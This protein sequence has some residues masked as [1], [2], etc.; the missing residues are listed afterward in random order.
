[1]RLDR[2][3][4][5]AAALSLL[6]GGVTPV[7][8]E[9]PAGKTTWADH[10]APIMEQ[11]CTYC[12]DA[13]SPSGGLDLTSYAGAMQGGGSGA[14]IVPG[15][16]D[17]S[18]LF[19][20]VSKAAQ[21]YMPDDGSELPAEA[22]ATLRRWIE[23]GALETSSSPAPRARKKPA[24]T[25]ESGPGAVR[26]G[27]A[28]PAALALAGRGGER[29]PPA[30]LALA[31]SPSA[32]L[33][34]VGGHREVLLYDT[35]GD[36]LVGVL[37]FPQGRVHV[38]RFSP[39]GQTLLAAGG[40]G[41]AGGRASLFEV[42]SGALRL[43]VDD[44]RD[45]F[46][47][48][49]VREDLAQLAVGGPTR[50]VAVHGLR[51]GAPSYEL[52]AHTDWITA[53]AFSPDGTLL[54]SADRA[55][56]LH[57]WEADSGQEFLDLEAHG[58]PITALAW[59]RD[60]ELLASA[61]DSGH[62]RLFQ[63][64]D[65][66]KH[67]E[68]LAHAGGALAVTWTPDGRLLSSG[69]DGKVVL[70]TADG[71]PQRVLGPLGAEG[72]AATWLEGALE[73]AA[74]PSTPAPTASPAGGGPSGARA[75]AGDLAGCVHGFALGADASV[76]ASASWPARA[77]SLTR[78]RDEARTALARAQ[79]GREDQERRAAETAAVAST[80]LEAGQ[81]AG[82]DA[83]EARALVS[84][85]PELLVSARQL[86]AGLES[87]LAA[88]R[89]H[90]QARA[91]A[92]AGDPGRGDPAPGDPAQDAVAAAERD[93]ARTAELQQALDEARAELA[94]VASQVAARRQVLDAAAARAEER[95]A[96]LEAGAREAAA[97]NLAATSA[98]TRAR[99]VER[100]AAREAQ[101]W[102]VEVELAQV[103]AALAAA[104]TRVSQARA[105]ADGA[106]A[107]RDTTARAQAQAVQAER[108]AREALAAAERAAAR[109]AETVPP[110]ETLRTALAESLRA[111]GEVAH[112]RSQALALA[113]PGEQAAAHVALLE[114][115]SR[116]ERLANEHA[117]A[118]AALEVARKE[119]AARQAA[120][121]QTRAGVDEAARSSARAAQAAE[122]A[123]AAAER[124]EAALLEATAGHSAL[125][126]QLEELTPRVAALRQG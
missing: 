37:P 28:M 15:D 26:R 90:A 96:A 32:P 59:R 7:R 121:S 40:E 108:S 100:G 17:G 94:S 123:R 52:T 104:R 97:A 115:E 95:A 44:A 63:A 25:L 66:K 116:R 39:D 35:R 118:G 109:V 42:A 47:A 106:L 24:L 14:V 88:A 34:A 27:G 31:A 18:R 3:L 75:Y 85:D 72:L 45:A 29:R 112:V 58:A 99:E 33:L 71:K 98:L 105:A 70:W 19:R 78:L 117:L 125:S 122:E 22:L 79:A 114:A 84:Q 38:L 120:L 68:W 93:R 107:A 103:Q 126:R 92:A 124:A 56:G 20:L 73:A 83:A 54:A 65:G 82:R 36:G 48:A 61:A 21:P 80:S 16:P 6:G 50:V 91:Q 111:A 13:G 69:R 49:D 1:M 30:V 64:Q 23:Q 67:K 46:L 4:C 102:A 62:L 110:L 5:L 113:A 9:E 87:A 51:P 74:A 81:A 86:V 101:R 2:R 119:S 10:V 60:G 89:S 12:H 77:P 41:A 57:L 11:A 76:V 55:G 43:A 8:A 53:L